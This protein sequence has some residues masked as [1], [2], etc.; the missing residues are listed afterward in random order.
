MDRVKPF[1]FTR[2]T[3]RLK[4]GLRKILGPLL[5]IIRSTRTFPERLKAERQA[6]QLEAVYGISVCYLT[7]QF[8]Q[9]PA[10]RNEFARGGEV[11][12][13]FLAESFPHAYPE[14]SL[15]YTVSS[16]PHPGQVNIVRKAKQNGL[17]VVLN[18]NGVAYQAWHGPGWEEPNRKMR[19]VHELADFIVYQSEFCR[20]G[21]LKFL[22][23]SKAPSAIIYNPVDI[24]LYQPGKNLTSRH[25]P[26]LLLGGNQYERYRFETALQVLKQVLARLPGARLMVTGKLWGENQQ[27]SMELAQRTIRDLGVEGRVQFLGAYSQEAAPQIFQN[28]DIL[29]H[30]KYNDPSPNLIS[31]ALASGLPVVYSA[32]GGV[33]ELVGAE[34]GIGLP[35]EQ[36]WEKISLPDPEK[37]AEA[38]VTIWE[39]HPH[40]AEAARQSAVER[41]ALEK[42]IRAHRE[43]FMKLLD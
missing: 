13:T 32:S 12:L 11:K 17:K 37:M 35:V 1:S 28:A 24:D 39:D 19:A 10:L 16:I 42:F 9:R 3:T 27:L 33:P 22:G 30:T 41:F 4:N 23:A 5:P 21:A 20:S 6:A 18:Q 7:S 31:E 8:P 34:A 14:A 15:L 40:Y 36:S 43:L 26:V 25:G 29:L 38:V 2:L